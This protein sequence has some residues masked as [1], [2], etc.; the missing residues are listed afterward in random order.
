MKI[1]ITFED[2][3]DGVKVISDPSFAQ[4]M[5]HMHD[6]APTPAMDYAM[7][8]LN[9]VREM[10]KEAGKKLKPKLSVAKKPEPT[11]DK[12]NGTNLGEPIFDEDFCHGENKHGHSDECI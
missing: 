11:E 7:S 3:P 6:E 5:L 9:K 1:T 10:S 2:Q 4:L 12:T 8:A